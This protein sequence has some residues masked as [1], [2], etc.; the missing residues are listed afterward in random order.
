MLQTGVDDRTM[1]HSFTQA[2]GRDPCFEAGF[3]QRFSSCHTC[4]YTHG[5]SYLVADRLTEQLVFFQS[6]LPS[7]FTRDMTRN[8]IR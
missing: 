7:T 5:T 3:T 1:V 8:V 4:T 2:A 6:P